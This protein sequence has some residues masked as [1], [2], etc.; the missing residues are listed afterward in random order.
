MSCYTINTGG[1]QGIICMPNIY[2]LTLDNGRV[3]PFEWHAS[4]GVIP[5]RKDLEPMD[6]KHIPKGFEDKAIIWMNENPD[7]CK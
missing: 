1:V 5:L 3:V 6:L 2:E 7:K 4:C